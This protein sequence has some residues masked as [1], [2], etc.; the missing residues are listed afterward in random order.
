MAT[1]ITMVIDKICKMTVKGVKLMLESYFSISHGVL[2]LWRKTRYPTPSRAWMG[3]NNYNRSW[4]QEN[5]LQIFGIPN[6]RILYFSKV[7]QF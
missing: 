5:R 6:T 7:C 2:E 3:L 1:L 4:S